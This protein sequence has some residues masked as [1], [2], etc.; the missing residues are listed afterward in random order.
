MYHDLCIQFL[1]LY[2]F[3][4]ARVEKADIQHLWETLLQVALSNKRKTIKFSDIQN[5]IARDRRWDMAG[6][7]DLLQQDEMFEEARTG[8]ANT[9][10]GKPKKFDEDPK[11]QQ[12]T[13]F[14]KT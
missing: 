5:A 9:A 6:L 8:H 11:A 4:E 2:Y 3:E 13:A 10:A 14:F 7:K 12:I 1:L